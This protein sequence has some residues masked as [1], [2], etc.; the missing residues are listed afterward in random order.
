MARTRTLAQLR[1][2]SLQLA[3]MENVSLFVDTSLAGEV[4]TYINQGISELWDLLIAAGGHEWYMSSND[5]TTD[6]VSDG[7]F[8]MPTDFYLLKGV[9][10]VDGDEVYRL[11][12]YGWRERNDDRYVGA[13]EIVQQG[14]P[15]RYRCSGA[16]SATSGA[17][18]PVIT[19][20]PEPDGEYTV[21]VWYYPHAPVLNADAD[22]WDGF[23]GWEEFVTVFAAIK[24]R[25]KEES[26][27]SDL[28]LRKQ[29]LTARIEGL[30]SQ[31]DSGESDKIFIADTFD[32]GWW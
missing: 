21:R 11:L 17:Y 14:R 2:E 13:L 23:N 24:L 22:V 26:D 16:V 4:D 19:L 12:P 3:D 30:A 20:T 8:A 28:L 6:A 29:E 9:D 1:T 7:I 5:I 10:L 32:D 27:A 18:T 15:R 31:R 25:N